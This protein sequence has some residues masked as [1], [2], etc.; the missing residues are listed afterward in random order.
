MAERRAPWLGH[1][2]RSHELPGA[3]RRSAVAEDEVGKR[4]GHSALDRSQF[5]AGIESEERWH[6][7]GRR[8]GVAQVAAYRAGVLHL[9]AA[10]LPRRPHQPIEPRRQTGLDNVGPCGERADADVIAALLDA[11]QVADGRNVEDVFIGRPPDPRRVVVG[12]PGDDRKHP[13]AQRL[14]RFR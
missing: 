4:H 14:K 3:K 7:V 2:H 13:P 5:D 9:D 11:A 12:A 1:D 6:A 10:D 8:R